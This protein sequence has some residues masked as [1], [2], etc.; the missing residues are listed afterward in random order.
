MS[1]LAPELAHMTH[2]DLENFISEYHCN[3]CTV[4]KLLD[5]YQIKT[6]PNKIS[7]LL[8]LTPSSELLCPYCNV[9]MDLKINSRNDFLRTNSKFSNPFCSLCGHKEYPQNSFTKCHCPGCVK[10]AREAKQTEKKRQRKYIRTMVSTE[11]FPSPFSLT[12]ISLKEAIYLLIFH[13]QSTSE[14]LGVFTPFADAETPIAP[15][16]KWK[17]IIETL[18]ERHL[19]R[20]DPESPLEAFEFKNHNA[21]DFI[22]HPYCVGYL[23]SFSDTPEKNAQG[24]S[25]II[26]TFKTGEWPTRWKKE[27]YATVHELWRQLTVGESLEYLHS[28][29][30]ERS[31]DFP[32]GD[33]T[34][35]RFEDIA[36]DF[37]TSTIYAF[38][39]S[40]VKNASDYYMRSSISKKQAANSVVG[41]IERIADKVRLGE[42]RLLHY[43]RL[44]GHV[45][46]ALFYT[47]FY[48]VLKI[49]EKGF[50]LS[51]SEWRALS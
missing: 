25:S 1:T 21:E 50:T 12:E 15:Q 41:G 23:A 46:S 22:Y 20:I 11:T 3:E 32:S 36:N 9:P 40:A 45:D 14:R 24:L 47:L 31:F 35:A 48:R 2:D 17:G 16:N 38:I 5:K 44:K 27:K 29:G 6:Q 18:Q 43:N 49:G 42:W 37:S 4:R 33:A 51:Y 28:K 13:V 7:K 30:E 26:S 19:I 34:I 10:K 39:H 8:P